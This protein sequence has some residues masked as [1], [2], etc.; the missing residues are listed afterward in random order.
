MVTLT[1]KSNQI[2]DLEDCDTS[3]NASEVIHRQT[4]FKKFD[5]I[6]HFVLTSRKAG[7]LS[8]SEAAV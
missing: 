7:T 1:E 5:T 8:W 4:T 3:V 2:M 6:V